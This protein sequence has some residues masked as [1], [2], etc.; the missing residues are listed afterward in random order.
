MSQNNPKYLEEL[1]AFD[2][3]LYE[4]ASSVVELAYKGGALD[5]KT[6]LLIAIALDAMAGAK[7]GVTSLSKKAK[8][9]GASEDEIREAIRLA[10]FIGANTTL[11]AA[12]GALE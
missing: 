3:A 11:Q 4:T 8:A 12:T 2:P 10:Y 1:K 5:R 9:E 6:K 7:G